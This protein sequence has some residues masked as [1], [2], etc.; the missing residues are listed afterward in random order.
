MAMT[1][2]RIIVKAESWVIA[3]SME[4][5]RHQIVTVDKIQVVVDHI[6]D[7]HEYLMGSVCTCRIA[8]AADSKRSLHQS[9]AAPLSCSMHSS[10]GSCSYL[11][12][13]LGKASG[14]H[15]VL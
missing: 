7:I 8:L 4:E 9:Q 1:A 2:G 3:V 10:S 15:R 14:P 12:K 6:S 13:H 5:R 11:L